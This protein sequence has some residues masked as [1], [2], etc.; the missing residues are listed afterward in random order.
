M[1]FDYESKAV[2]RPRQGKTVLRKIKS[3]NIVSVTKRDTI[4][5]SEAGKQSAVHFYTH[6]DIIGAN[7]LRK[8][9]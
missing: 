4:M 3:I 5:L 1:L 2:F 8:H 9:N 7:Y 6:I